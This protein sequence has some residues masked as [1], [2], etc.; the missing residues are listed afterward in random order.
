MRRPAHRRGYRVYGEAD[1]HALRFVRRARGLGFS[2]EETRAL[3]ALW[4]DRSRASADVRRWRS[5][6]SRPA[7]AEIEAMLA[8]PAAPRR[9]LPRR[10]APRLPDPRRPRRRPPGRP[11]R[12][13]IRKAGPAATPR[14]G[15]AIPSVA[16]A[17]P[18]ALTASL[19]S[20]LLRGLRRNP[21]A[22]P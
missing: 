20:C 10:R 6:T 19:A 7:L 22:S 16:F 5:A 13:A 2:L 3:L 4:Q 12:H 15:N 9:E 1:V 21:G 18:D 8:H 17:A 14:Q 11:A